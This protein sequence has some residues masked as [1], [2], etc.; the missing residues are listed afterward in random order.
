MDWSFGTIYTHDLK[1]KESSYSAEREEFLSGTPLP[2][3]DMVAGTDGNLYF[4]TGGRRIDSHLFRLRY[5]GTDRASAENT[6]NQVSE[7]L[8]KLRRDIEKYHTQILTNAIP[9]AWKNLNHSDRFIRYAS[10]IAL[11]HQPVKQWQNLFFEETDPEKI[12]EASI[13]LARQGDKSLQSQ[14]VNKLNR[15]PFEKL[16]TH[17]QI[18]MLRSYQ[19]LFIRMGTPNVTDRQTTAKRLKAY[20]PHTNNAINGEL[21]LLLLYLKAD[22][23]TEGLVL[24]FDKHTK[25]KTRGNSKFLPEE[26]TLR[27]EEYG[28]IIRDIISKIPPS[29]AIYYGVL[30]SHAESGWTKNTRKKYFQWFYDVLSAKGGLSFKPGM[31]NICLAAMK[32]VPEKEKDYYQEFSGV[33]SLSL[34]IADLPQP[35]GPGRANTTVTILVI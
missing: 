1:P 15:L 5:I 34:A 2:L 14:I 12:V 13:G 35:I 8:R 23:I 4:T 19:L 32:H 7:N 26:T 18:D 29:E 3:T 30:L 27:S 22:G 24:L 6:S 16:S 28:P 25:E 33:Y 20:F 11:E 10:R 17:Q 21:G 9:L 31:E